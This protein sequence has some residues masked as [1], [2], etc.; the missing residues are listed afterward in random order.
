MPP[1]QEGPGSPTTTQTQDSV[2]KHTLKGHPHSLSGLKAQGSS[3][4]QQRQGGRSVVP[5]QL[6]S[7]ECKHDVS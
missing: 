3:P 2:C 1:W 6:L 5:T 4:L 7:S